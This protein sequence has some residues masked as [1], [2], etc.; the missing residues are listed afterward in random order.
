MGGCQDEPQWLK[1]QDAMIDA[2]IRLGKALKSHIRVLK[3]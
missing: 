1:I 3:V 2:M